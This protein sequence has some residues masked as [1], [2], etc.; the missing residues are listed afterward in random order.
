MSRPLRPAD[1]NYAERV[2]ESF[3]RQTVMSTIGARLTRVA[4]GEVDIEMPYR[5]DLVQQHGFVHAGILAAIA[6]SA[7]G[8]AAYSLMPAGAAVLSIE[9]KINLLAPARG[10]ML[11]ARARV[12]RAGRNITSCLAEVSARHAGEETLV[13]TLLGTMMTVH[14]RPGLDG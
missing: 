3:A 14:E 1:E 5:D 2:R 6:D 12:L 4:P 10:E 7:C 13:A 9:F 11:F 8:Y